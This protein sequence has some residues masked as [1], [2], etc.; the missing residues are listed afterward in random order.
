[1]KCAPPGCSKNSPVTWQQLVELTI[2]GVF[3]LFQ[4]HVQMAV[5]NAQIIG[6][7]VQILQE[8][9]GHRLRIPADA[10]VLVHQKQKL[11]EM[12]LEIYW[13]S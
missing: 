1:M 4:Q 6:V 7:L 2:I 10:V 3:P 12:E 9:T 5:S 13:E 8:G 11:Y